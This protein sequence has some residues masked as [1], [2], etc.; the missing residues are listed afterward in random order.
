MDISHSYIIEYPKGDRRD[1]LLR[2]WIQDL[3]ET[4]KSVGIDQ[5][6]DVHYMKCS[7]KLGYKVSDADTFIE[8]L[9]MMPHGILSVGVIDNAE[10]MSEIVQNKLLKTIEEPPAR[11]VVILVTSNRNSLLQTIRSRCTIL[12]E[13]GIRSASEEVASNRE[14]SKAVDAFYQSEFFHEFRKVI[15]KDITC[16]EDALNFIDD[17]ILNFQRGLLNEDKRED[18]IYGIEKAEELRIDILRGMGYMQ[19]MKRFYLE[20]HAGNK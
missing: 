4:D 13:Y 7:G 8:S 2:R 1:I 10:S 18:S 11:T 19:G 5:H 6:E 9:M 14:I 15:E 17:I 12:N 20:F 16:K 3:I